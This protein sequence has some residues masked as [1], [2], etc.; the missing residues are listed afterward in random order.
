MELNSDFL[1][2]IFFKTCI[3]AWIHLL[4]HCVPRFGTLCISRMGT[5][6]SYPVQS[7]TAMASD[8]P[9]PRYHAGGGSHVGTARTSSVCWTGRGSCSR[10]SSL[11]LPATARTDKAIRSIA[12]K[13]T[14]PPEAPVLPHTADCRAAFPHTFV[15]LLLPSALL[16]L[17]LPHPRF[18][19]C[20]AAPEWKYLSRRY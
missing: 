15:L 8:C 3:S 10:Q 4:V 12:D 5:N 1:L 13:T 20:R 7:R 16:P 2:L 14:C 9:C 17:S 11:T 19:L 18:S 6:P